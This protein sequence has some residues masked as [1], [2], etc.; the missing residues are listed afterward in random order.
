MTLSPAEA[1][2]LATQLARA[3]GLVDTAG[4]ALRFDPPRSPRK[5][6]DPRPALRAALEGVT[7]RRSA[8]SVGRALAALASSVGAARPFRR[9]LAELDQVVAQAT[10]SR[11]KRAERGRVL[12][13]LLVLF[14]LD[15]ALD[16]GPS[17]DL[18]G[19]TRAARRGIER[20]LRA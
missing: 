11:T 8:P 20:C 4:A 7:P 1:A 17:A 12:A 13:Q 2:A 3:F 5:G 14:E 18:E 16:P 6:V 10:F 9:A 19:A 15:G